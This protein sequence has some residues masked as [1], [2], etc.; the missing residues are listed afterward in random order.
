MFSKKIILL[1][2]VAFASFTSCKKDAAADNAALLTTGKWKLTAQTDAGKDAFTS[3]LAC[4]KD[5]ITYF[6]ADGKGV[7]DEG[8]TKCAA[9][10]PQTSPF[11]W[12]FADAAK[13]QVV[14]TDSGFALTC[15]IIELTATTLKWSIVNPFGGTTIVQTYSKI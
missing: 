8:A 11:T 2:L 13:T 1:A 12:V 4:E 6:T 14:V 15:T 10:D 5:D 7:S 3:K 9:T